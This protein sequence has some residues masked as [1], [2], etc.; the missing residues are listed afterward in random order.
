M[1]SRRINLYTSDQYQESEMQWWREGKETILFYINENH[2]ILQVKERNHFH[3]DFNTV[4][5]WRYL[6]LVTSYELDDQEIGILVIN[7]SN[8]ELNPICQ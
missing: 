1:A 4:M 3:A 5:E 7:L 2:N 8:T 6:S